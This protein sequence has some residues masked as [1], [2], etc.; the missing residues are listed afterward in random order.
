MAA[1]V[2]IKFEV[3][4]EIKPITYEVTLSFDQP[5]IQPSKFD[6]N[7]R[8]IW[9][10]IEENSNGCNGFN[11]S[12][13]MHKIITSLKLKKGSHFYI[14]KLKGDN[15]TFFAISPDG[16]KYF[17][18]DDIATNESRTEKADIQVDYKPSEPSDQE[19]L[20]VLW[21]HHKNN[22]LDV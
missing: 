18:I 13:D 20:R 9:Y 11:A 10:G 3:S 12:E 21:E 1:S 17:T 7:K 19:K 15:Y 6:E 14:K 5:L 16:R 8:S 4:T 2:P 22:F